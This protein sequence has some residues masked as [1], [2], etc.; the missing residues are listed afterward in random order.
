MTDT[1]AA[2]IA[3]ERG[4]GLVTDNGKYS[5][6]RRRETALCEREDLN[7]EPTLWHLAWGRLSVGSVSPKAGRPECSLSF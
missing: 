5:Y 1:I 6:I 4:C 2:L 7:V 3:I